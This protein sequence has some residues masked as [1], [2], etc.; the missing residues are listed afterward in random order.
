[1]EGKAGA[2]FGDPLLIAKKQVVAIVPARNE[3]EGIGASIESLLNQD[4]EPAPEVIV[5]ND[6]ST[7][8]TVAVAKAAGERGGQSRSPSEPRSEL[9]H[10]M[11]RD[12][13]VYVFV[14]AEA[15][16]PAPQT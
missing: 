13:C 8:E 15:V 2:A 14:H 7:D 4:F 3:A 1:L 12:D 5:V 9:K 11:D 6:D 10:D 16:S